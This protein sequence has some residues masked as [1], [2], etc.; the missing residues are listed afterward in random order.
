MSDSLTTLCPAESTSRPGRAEILLAGLIVLAGL[1]LRIAW[2]S[3]L[4]VEH[5]DEGVYA[6]NLFFHDRAGAGHYPDQHLYA[7]PLLPFLIE[8]SMIAFGT[9]NFAAMLVNIV[10]GALT[11]PLV[12]WVGRR[13]FGATAGLTAA[14]L[15]AL[16]DVHIFF[17]RTALTDVL[18]CFFLVGAVFFVSET[19]AARQRLSTRH[20][21]AL[22]AAGG[23]TGLAWWT[24]YNGWLPL[25]IGL[26]GLVPWSLSPESGAP[27]TQQSS[28]LYLERA[29]RL[30][31]G[32]LA[33]WSIVAVTAFLI[34][35]PWLLSLQERGGYAVVAA[36]H[37]SYIV[38]PS[39]W[40]NS[41]ATQVRM[42]SVLDG[43][44]TS[45]SL[46]V[47]FAVSMIRLRQDDRCFTWNILLRNDAVFLTLA[48]IGLVCVMPGANVILAVLGVVGIIVGIIRRLS[49]PRGATETANGDLALWLVTAWFV[50]LLFTIPLYTPYPRL[51]L[52]LLVASWLGTG[53]LAEVVVGRIRSHADEL[54]AIKQWSISLLALKRPQAI[55]L[56]RVQPLVGMAVCVW[57][58]VAA[59]Q[60][61]P[62]ERGV[63][64]WEPRTSL[65]KLAPSI[66][67]DA[68]HDAR[69]DRESQLEKLVIYVYGEPALVFNL[70]LA[71]AEFV[72]PVKDVAFADSEAPAPR[73]P[74]FVVIGPQAWRTR[75]FGEQLVTALPRLQLV[76]SYRYAP[77]ELVDLDDPMSR[78]DRPAEHKLDLY[79]V[80]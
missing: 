38:G 49:G 65:A 50:G 44:P 16:N 74:S 30:L 40:R 18:L 17:S 55:A 23:T 71:G 31:P 21:L 46:L 24:K 4:A 48:V 1:S 32:A 13:W 45:C 42:L 14:T 22:F 63:P 51:V 20:W 25:A 57:I 59:V 61:S 80:K 77:S 15:A 28:W 53:I 69:L 66:L 73:L 36:N 68:C 64:G 39:E 70:R 79:R 8:C 3:R 72:N 67:E 9:S 41:F 75:G 78:P 29:R 7:P 52:P 5:F 33:C 47:V 58:V 34:W 10:A 2:P 56:A 26:A 54:L 12:W 43:I 6:S 76:G 27:R 62:L 11:V 37:R 35:A 60:R 19:L